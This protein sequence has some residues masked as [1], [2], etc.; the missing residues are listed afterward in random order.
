MLGWCPPHISFA[1]P[2]VGSSL[3]PGPDQ[4]AE[5][6]A[7]RNLCRALAPRSLRSLRSLRSALDRAAGGLGL[8]PETLPEKR[9]QV[10]DVAAFVL[11]IAGR[12]GHV[13]HVLVLLYLLL[14]PFADF[15]RVAV[16]QLA[17]V[18]PVAGQRLDGLGEAV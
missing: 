1:Y 12:G 3:M 6:Q 11:F 2:S 4:Q 16:R 18:E 7:L 14:D 5:L 8:H 15:L 10:D 17:H 9:H 13:H